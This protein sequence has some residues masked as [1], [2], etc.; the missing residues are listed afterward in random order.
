MR[1]K[2]I[3]GNWKMNKNNHETIEF[4]KVADEFKQENIIHGVAVPAPYLMTANYLANNLVVCAQNCHFEDKGAFTGETSPMMLKDLEINWCVVGHSERREYFN[5]SDEII[6]KKVLALLKHHISP[7]LCCGETLHQYSNNETKSVV[8]NQLRKNLASVSA[9]EV[10]HVVIAYE[11]IW[12]IGTGKTA[13]AEIAEDVCKFIRE[14]LSKLYDEKT[15]NKVLI[16]YG[17]S[18]KPD[19]IKELLNKPNID[20]ALVGGASLEIN[21]Y[22]ALLK[23]I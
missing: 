18:V 9:D 13:T 20:G 23:N 8:E 11:P 17:G 10:V 16:Q 15:A 6:N 1:K 7:I 5:E 14:T 21:S 12:A 3:I 19:N 4:I 2:I 22:L